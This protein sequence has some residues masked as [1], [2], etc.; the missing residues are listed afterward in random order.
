MTQPTDSICPR[1]IEGAPSILEISAESVRDKSLR[2]GHI[3]T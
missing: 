1:L 2:L 3:S